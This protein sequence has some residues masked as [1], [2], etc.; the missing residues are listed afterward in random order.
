M[1][2]ITILSENQHIVSSDLANQYRILP[3]SV[4]ENTLELYVDDSYNNADA[5][6]ELELFLGKNIIFIHIDS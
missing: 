6:E 1:Q 3:K 5:K 4:S 2:E